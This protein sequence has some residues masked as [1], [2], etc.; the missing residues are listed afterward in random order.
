MKKLIKFFILFLLMNLFL[1]KQAVSLV[2]DNLSFDFQAQPGEKI[3]GKISLRNDEN[4]IINIKVYQTDYLFY[5][6]GEN[7][8]N[9]P[10][11]NSRSNANW[12]SFSPSR[13]SIPPQE[14]GAI[15]FTINVPQDQNLK[16]AYWS[17][18]MIEPVSEDSFEAPFAEKDKLKFGV[19]IQLRYAVQI[20][21]NIGE[22]SA[23]VK[24]QEKKITK[25]KGEVCLY[26]SLENTGEKM[27]IPEVSAEL[28][29]KNGLSLGSFKSLSGQNRIYPG[30][31]VKHKI[32]FGEL[33]S[34]QYKVLVLVDNKDENVFGAQYTIKVQ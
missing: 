27:L 5:A 11:T 3:E 30:C 29:D 8:Y 16:G 25:E 22:G 33:K 20:A 1:P 4:K 14:R 31:S 34:G 10:G 13:F 2:V 12:I 17:M 9:D 7:Y 32:N 18:I 26:L 28:I 15:Y 6:N 24:F 21:V 19:Q 23:M